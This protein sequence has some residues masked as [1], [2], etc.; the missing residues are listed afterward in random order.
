MMS[1]CVGRR[2]WAG[3]TARKGTEFP[4]LPGPAPKDLALTG[5]TGHYR[6]VG[7]DGTLV[8]FGNG[9]GRLKLR[10]LSL[11]GRGRGG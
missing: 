10:A 5:G 3:P 1:E 8:E 2:R 11:A 4:N 6:N 9:K 7:G